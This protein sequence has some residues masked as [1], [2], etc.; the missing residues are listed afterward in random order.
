MPKPL[1]LTQ[2]LS[3]FATLDSVSLAEKNHEISL[4]FSKVCF[5]LYIKIFIA[6]TQ[7][8]S[9]RES[10]QYLYHLLEDCIFIPR[11]QR[12]LNNPKLGTQS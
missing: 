5:T 1:H 9:F 3:S 6:I 11:F 4:E 7:R 10:H 2:V 8:S 12:L